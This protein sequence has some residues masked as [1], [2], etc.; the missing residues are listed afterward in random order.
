MSSIPP[1][2]ST[3]PHAINWNDQAVNKEAEKTTIIYK[4]HIDGQP[5]QVTVGYNNAA[6]RSQMKIE[7][8]PKV[9]ETI[10]KIVKEMKPEDL[11]KLVGHQIKMNL[12]APETDSVQVFHEENDHTLTKDSDS[13]LLESA[14]NISRLFNQTLKPLAP[15]PTSTPISL[16]VERDPTIQDEADRITATAAK[17]PKVILNDQFRSIRQIWRYEKGG[18]AEEIVDRVDT[19]KDLQ[20]AAHKEQDYLKDLQKKTSDPAKIQTINTRLQALDKTIAKCAEAKT[21]WA[22]SDYFRDKLRGKAELNFEKGADAVI[23]A[24][25]KIIE[26]NYYPAAP[27]VN[28]RYHKCQAGTEE[29]GWLRVGVVSDMSNGFT[30][31]KALNELSSA[32]DEN[33]DPDTLRNEMA[34]NI[35]T[36][37][38]KAK[39][40]G[41]HNVDASAGYALKQLGYTPGQIKGAFISRKLDIPLDD[42]AKKII[43]ETVEKRKQVLSSQFLQIVMEQSKHLSPEDIESGTLKILHVSLLNQQSK[44]IDSTGWNHDEENEMLDMAEIFKLFN[45]KQL[46]QDNKGPFI[47]L[48]GNI[49]LPNIGG[50]LSLQALFF[51]QSVQGNTKNDRTQQEINEATL[52]DTKMDLTHPLSKSLDRENTSYTSAA[53]MIFKGIEIGYKVSCGCLSAK[54]RTGFVSACVADRVMEKAQFSKEARAEFMRGQIKEDSPAVKIIRDN[55]GTKIMK[56]SPFFIEGFTEGPLATP[57]NFLQRMLLYITQGIEILKE[58]RRIK[59]REISAP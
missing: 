38:G 8:D 47:D 40:K 41:K 29:A 23:T 36:Q 30:N 19:F 11:I 17:A 55:T 58:R 57:L 39:E 3:A 43:G 15:T 6:L 49:H 10:D 56:V 25:E 32:I 45:G 14:N 54:D 37:W 2:T 33:L 44:K 7:T 1:T 48:E 59:A 4:V 5:Y 13:S 21:T 9:L 18:E 34:N 52:F 20:E 53:D 46:V 16:A 22:N 24:Y 28:M 35:L 27:P 51:N 31:L 42:R 12:N 26:N 50:D